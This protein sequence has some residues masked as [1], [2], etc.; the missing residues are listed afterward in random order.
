[1]KCRH[2]QHAR[3]SHRRI[4]YKLKKKTLKIPGPFYTF[5]LSWL[6]LTGKKSYFARWKKL[7]LVE[8]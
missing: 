7:K 4:I 2:P 8:I 5:Q 6:I 3:L 1:V